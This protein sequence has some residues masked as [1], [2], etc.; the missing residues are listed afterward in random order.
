MVMPMKKCY[1]I[2]LSVFVFG[3]GAASAAPAFPADKNLP[4]L[5][6][7][8]RL[9]GNSTPDPLPQPEVH[10]YTIT[11]GEEKI[12]QDAFNVRE[13]WYASQH[14]GQW[15]D[16]AGNIMIVAQ[17]TV[18]LPVVKETI[19]NHAT[20][21]AY[22]KAV[23]ES[24]VALDASSG[25]EALSTWMASFAGVTPTG[26][27]KLRTQQ[28]FNL[29]DALFFPMGDTKTLAWAFRVKV[30]SM[31]GQVKPSDWYAVV[32]QVN[33]GAPLQ[34]VRQEFEMQFFKGV[35][36]VSPTAATSANAPKPA[37]KLG[38]TPAGGASATPGRDEVIKSIENM[39]GWWYVEAANYIFLS[40]I[41]GAAGKSLIRDLQNTLPILRQGFAKTVAPFSDKTDVNVVR[42]FESKE[43]YA[44]YVGEGLE[45]SAGCW[46]PSRR[47]LCILSQG[48]QSTDKAE[49]ERTAVIVRHEAF[50]QYLFYASDGIQDATWYNE[51]HAC[52]FEASGIDAQKRVE[53]KDSDQKPTL[54]GNLDEAVQNIPFILSANHAQ[55]YAGD[56]KKRGLNYATAWGLVYFLHCGTSYGKTAAY[57]NILDTYRKTL[58]ETKNAETATQK[59]FEDVDMKAFQAAFREFWSKGGTSKRFRVN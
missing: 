13:L 38:A 50:H 24:G 25:G 58:R 6:L 7:K 52:F 39:E 15:R 44:N 3:H 12:Q 41:K 17:A 1:S 45:W 33:D 37:A 16:T 40:N 46:M 28:N 30:R 56:D 31:N 32:L 10:S 51:G 29:T 42:I 48:A 8:I 4:N 36:A 43:A 11:R 27:E 57:A 55:F 49:K 19:N 23:K 54:M 47:E 53:V 21:E 14:A 34:K 20:R 26:V 35:A 2:L 59:A 5:G 9:L 18:Q 22:E